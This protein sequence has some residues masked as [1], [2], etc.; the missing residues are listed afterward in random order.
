ML[1]GL[2]PVVQQEMTFAEA[3]E[4][5]LAGKKIRHAK[6][7]EGACVFVHANFLHLRKADG[8]LHSLIVSE[9]DLTA[10]DWTIVREN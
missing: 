10:T 5:L 7:D 4:P 9:D 3:V 6:M 8:S 2:S 1:T